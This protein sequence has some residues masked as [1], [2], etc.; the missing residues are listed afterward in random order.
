MILICYRVIAV[1]LGILKMSIV[2]AIASFARVCQ[3]V[4]PVGEIDDV[5]RSARLRSAL[6][7]ILG[8]HGVRPDAPL[9][10][11]GGTNLYVF[12]RLRARG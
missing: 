5:S 4:Y 7:K 1:L 8:E 9:S 6:L 12:A 10:Q 3:E 2:D 11:A